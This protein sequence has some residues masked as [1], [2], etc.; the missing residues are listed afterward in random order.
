MLF[1]RDSNLFK[2]RFKE[3]IRNALHPG[4]FI[5]N[6]S[7]ASS[8]NLAI[9]L[10]QFTLSPIITRI[11]TPY[12]YGIFTVFSSI[13]V[14]LS[15]LGSL[16]YNEAIVL[17]STHTERNN[18][19][20]LSGILVLCVSFLSWIGVVF[21]SSDLVSFLNEPRLLKF[22]YFIPLGVGLVGTIE[23]LLSINVWNKRFFNNGLAGFFTNITSRI[24]TIAFGLFIQPVAVGLISGDLIGKASG[25]LTIIFTSR[26]FRKKFIDQIRSIS[27]R[28]MVAIASVYKY[29]P[30]Y[31]LPTSIITTLS[32]HLPIYFFQAKYS[33][34]IV[35]AYA[36]SASLLEI[37]NRLIPYSVAGVFFSKAVELKN[38][39]SDQLTRATYKVFKVVFVISLFI[40]IVSSATS[41]YVFPF[42][43]GE[44]WKLAGVFAGILSVSYATNFINVSLLEIYKVISKEKLLLNTTIIS[45]LIKVV[46]LVLLSYSDVDA[47][48]G[49]FYFCIASALGN[50]FQILIVLAKLNLKLWPISLAMVVMETV[51]VTVTYFVNLY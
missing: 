28:S 49:L 24:F 30:L 41:R 15:M 42:I 51:I 3:V 39:S 44:S 12:Q 38:Q 8:W 7:I 45:V 31:I 50:I 46:T 16:K 23:I 9:I 27:I 26:S 34:A 10:V 21:F 6:V 36:L 22:I 48:N 43:F 1:M 33:S 20:S 13:I 40:F 32:N 25:S 4:S 2:Y 29:F 19:A 47:S 18:I 17:A 37:V 14:N 5:Q 35:G 11:Y